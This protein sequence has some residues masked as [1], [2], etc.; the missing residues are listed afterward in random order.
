MGE[1]ANVVPR[2]ADS[3][4]TPFDLAF[5]TFKNLAFTPT[6]KM[7]FS[8]PLRWTRLRAACSS[9][10]VARYSFVNLII[11]FLD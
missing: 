3:P 4:P 5:Y 2:G 8:I 7:S 1:T 11:T 10:F 6:I 9:F